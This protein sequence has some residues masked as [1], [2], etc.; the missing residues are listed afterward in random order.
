MSH[1]I[2]RSLMTVGLAF[3]LTLSACGTGDSACAAVPMPAPPPAPRPAPAPRPVYK[4]PA[5]KPA[6]PKP[7]APKAA[8]KPPPPPPKIYRPAS[9]RMD[10]FSPT[11]D[12]RSY[13]NRPATDHTPLLL[14]LAMNG[15]FSP[16]HPAPS[17]QPR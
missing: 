7:A 15:A 17:C 10:R 14:V 13:Y 6:A 1:V 16:S 11:Y 3:V 4:A 8:P 12:Y 2:S 5:P 9:P